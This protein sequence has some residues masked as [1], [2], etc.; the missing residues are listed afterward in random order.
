VTDEPV[1]ARD[2]VRKR[3]GT[4]RAPETGR[5]HHIG[6]APEKQPLLGEDGAEYVETAAVQLAQ[7]TVAQLRAQRD[8]DA[9]RMAA[10][11]EALDFEGAARLRDAVAAVDAELQ[12]RGG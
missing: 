7:R 2:L 4:Y 9:A 11:A 6:A 1:S 8:R 12:R 3:R 5:H 10:A